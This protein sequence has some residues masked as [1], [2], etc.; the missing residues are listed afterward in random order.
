VKKHLKVLQA[1]GN[2]QKKISILGPACSFAEHFG[3]RA[4][5]SLCGNCIS[6]LFHSSLAAI[7]SW[8]NLLVQ[9]A[10]FPT[11]NI[12]GHYSA[13]VHNDDR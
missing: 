6:H 8:V 3:D 13:L 2:T 5:W 1:V 10:D 7:G 11:C 12:S 4:A 9:I